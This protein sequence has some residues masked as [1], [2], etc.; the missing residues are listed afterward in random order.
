M[1]GR[2]S[3]SRGERPG[4]GA[5]TGTRHEPWGDFPVRR[6][7][8]GMGT[9]AFGGA[10]ERAVMWAGESVAAIH[11]VRPAAEILADLV[12]AECALHGAV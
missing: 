3:S 12:D 2:R 9:P 5:I 10:V 8:V 11:D 7:Q 1:A 6:C 4:E